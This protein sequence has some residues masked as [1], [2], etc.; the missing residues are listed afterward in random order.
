MQTIEGS[1]TTLKVKVIGKPKPDI[2]WLREDEEI[3]PSDEYQ[4]ENKPDGTSVL[5]INKVHPDD[6]GKITFEAYN[7]VGAAETVT[8]LL[9]E[10]ICLST[11]TK[12]LFLNHMLFIFKI[13]FSERTEVFNF[14]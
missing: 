5:V 14:I 3:I 8:E 11:R 10:G 12:M 2:K 13:F 4:I 1:V 6:T 7:S 9:V